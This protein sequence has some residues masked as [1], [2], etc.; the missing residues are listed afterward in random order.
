VA[1]AGAAAGAADE[2][3][4]AGV[5]AIESGLDVDE[6]LRA[7]GVLEVGRTVLLGGADCVTGWDAAGVEVAGFFTSAAGVAFGRGI[8]VPVD[9]VTVDFGTLGRREAG[10]AAADGALEALNR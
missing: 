10:V 2:A 5:E 7:A 4:G 6:I 3:A 1:A 9:G 8:A